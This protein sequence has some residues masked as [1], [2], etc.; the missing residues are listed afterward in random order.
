[1]TDSTQAIVERALDHAAQGWMVAHVERAYWLWG[2]AN[3]ACFGCALSTPFIEIATPRPTDNRA[4]HAFADIGPGEDYG[5]RLA[6]RIHP[7]LLRGTDPD[8]ARTL[9]SYLLH[10]QVHGW[11]LDALGWDWDPDNDWHG[12]TFQ[13]KL[14]EVERAYSLDLTVTRR[15]TWR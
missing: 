6:V 5:V 7:E 4:G 15:S 2:H 8:Y 3:R 13:S 9:D 14:A 10:E 11:Q 1:M 12:R